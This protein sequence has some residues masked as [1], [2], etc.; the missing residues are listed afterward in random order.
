MRNAFLLIE[1]ANSHAENI[2]NTKVHPR[3]HKQTEDQTSGTGK[4][5]QHAVQ[6]L[7]DYNKIAFRDAQETT[8]YHHPTRE[9]N[10]T[11]WQEICQE[12][13]TQTQRIQPLP[14]REDDPRNEHDRRSQSLE[15]KRHIIDG[16][17]DATDRPRLAITDTTVL[18]IPT[19]SGG[20]M[21]G[22]T[23]LLHRPTHFFGIEIHRSYPRHRGH[24][25]LL[26]ENF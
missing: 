12:R 25:S 26:I 9:H 5:P 19:P 10:R 23:S 24:E 16:L 15:G 22:C 20:L 6:G 3:G 13:E 11:A 18:T 1:S 14:E 4:E 21:R 7:Q 8:K 2:W 17:F